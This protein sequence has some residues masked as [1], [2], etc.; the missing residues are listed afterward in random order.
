MQFRLIT[1][2]IHKGIGG[3]DRLYR[4]E[5]VIATLERY[6]ADIVLMQEVDDDVPRSSHH[7]QVDEIGDALDL[8]HRAFQRNVRLK[9]G[10]YGNAILSRFPL[11]DVENLDLTVPMK[12][13]RQAL[14]ARCQ[15]REQHQRTMLLINCHLGLAGYERVQQLQRMLACRTLRLTHR[16]TPVIAAGDYNDV[17]GTLGRRCMQ[18]AGFLSVSRKVNTFPAVMP[19]RQL[20]HIFYRGEVDFLHSFPGRSDIARLASDHLPLIADLELPDV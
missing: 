10:Y 4:L 1:Y 3:V 16:D 20:D 14:V 15:V 19:V 13:R 7:R 9:Q 17:W 12:K 18:P 6:G 2:N 5:R 8:R 11:S